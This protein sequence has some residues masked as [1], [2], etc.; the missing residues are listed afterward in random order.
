[1]AIDESLQKFIEFKSL[2]QEYKQQDLSESDTRSKVIDFMFRSV[3]DWTEQS[4]RREGHNKQGYYDYKIE[5]PGFRFIV[6]A[7]RQFAQFSLP[8]KHK[9]TT[10]NVLL[11]GNQ[12]IIEQVRGY[13]IE[14]SIP[15]AV[16]TNGQQFVFMKTFNTDGTSWKTNSCLIFNG[17]DDIEARFIEFYE[18]LSK[19]GITSNGGFNYLTPQ[20]TEEPKTVLSRLPDRDLIRNSITVGMAPLIEKIFG[21]IFLDGK[22]DDKELIKSCF[23]ENEETKK[24]RSEIE[25]LFNDAAPELN[26][27]IPALNA[28]NIGNQIIAEISD[29]EVNI[30]SAYPPKPIILIGSKGA[31]KTTFINHLFKYR[32][33]EG[34]L[35]EHLVVYVDFRKFYETDTDFE[36]RKIAKDI[37]ETIYEKYPELELHT[38]RTLIRMYRQEIKRN[39]ENIWEWDKANDEKS[40]MAKQ[41]VFFE[42]AMNDMLMHL[43]KLS[44]YLI[45]ERRKRLIV[46]IDNADQFKEIIQEK[47][48]LFSHSLTKKALC[49][50]I[51]SLREGYYYKRQ[52]TPPFDA[53]ESNVYHISAPRYIEVLEKRINYAIQKAPELEGKV[54]SVNTRGGAYNFSVDYLVS[55]LQ[56]LKDSLLQL[57]NTQILDFLSAT[58]YPNIREGLRLFKSF[59]T[60]GHT[61][62]AE[63]ASRYKPEGRDDRTFPHI[64]FHEFF[65]S[66]TLQN[67]HYFNSENSLTVN[68][69]MPPSGTRDHFI[70]VYI[71]KELSNFIQTQRFTERYVPIETLMDKFLSFGYTSDILTSALKFLFQ[72]G[73]VDTDN[74]I[75]DTEFIDLPATYEISVTNKGYYYL[76]FLLTEFFYIDLILQDTPIFSDE[77]YNRIASEFPTAKNDGKRDLVKRVQVAL[78]F[79]DYLESMEAIQPTVIK[80]AYGNICPLIKKKLSRDMSN[81]A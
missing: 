14:E 76:S 65:K 47:V 6:E 51:I 24:N 3:L 34:T 4:I 30:H 41:A 59:L 62:A 60:S 54:T 9:K 61:K 29:D 1:M 33:E 69:F 13:C 16:I 53:Y 31:G 26:R 73:L 70:N 15:F 18:N 27:V 32:L 50:T 44:V 52:N 56:I 80:K 37:V 12:E 42:V 68:L 57:Q 11:K 7:K 17:F 19:T 2:Y 81:Y 22:E 23:V 77:F 35:E 39:D 28:K 40:Y 10:L 20:L 55:F 71:L 8:A 78:D 64:P 49:G 45:R 48:F 21:E 38:R 74:Q 63:Y 43:E 58:T 67:K 25:K 72:K 36:P 66:V 46:I 5:I 79:I 75:S